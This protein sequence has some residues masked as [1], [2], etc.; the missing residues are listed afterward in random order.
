MQVADWGLGDVWSPGPALDAYMMFMRYGDQC[1]I[2][3]DETLGLDELE[4]YVKEREAEVAS[5]GEPE[6]QGRI[7][8]SGEPYCK[9]I[10]FKK[11]NIGDDLLR[12]NAVDTSEYTP[13]KVRRK[14]RT[15]DVNSYQYSEPDAKKRWPEKFISPE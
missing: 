15:A 12:R 7:S 8:T 1:V 13:G 2:R 11:F 9:P 3:A 4:G 6:G 5:G 10:Y 14:R